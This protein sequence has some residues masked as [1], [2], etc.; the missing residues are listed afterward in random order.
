MT[1]AAHISGMSTGIASTT[2]K[3]RRVNITG[4]GEVVISGD[5]K[6]RGGRG[7]NG[8]AIGTLPDGSNELPDLTITHT[9]LIDDAVRDHGVWDEDYEA[10][11][12]PIDTIGITGGDINDQFTAT[13]LLELFD[14]GA[15]RFSEPEDVPIASIDRALQGELREDVLRWYL[16][17]H[18]ADADTFDDE[19]S[20]YGADGPSGIITRDGHRVILDGCHRYATA[21]L[22]GDTTF[23]MQFL[24]F[25][26]SV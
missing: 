17:E 11:L 7:T 5:G 8:G 14:K 9:Q 24:R 3:P 18:R 13:E 25:P 20:F 1:S 26:G 21:R 19:I 4:V 23:R 12:I 22:R 16:E 2:Q 6:I 10:T 15:I